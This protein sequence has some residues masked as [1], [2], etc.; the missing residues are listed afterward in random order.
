MSFNSADCA[1]FYAENGYFVYENALAT[2]TVEMLQQDATR[3]CGGD[4]G[5]VRGLLPIDSD[6]SDDDILGRYVCIHFPH[7]LS[8]LMYDTLA[9]P[10]MVDVLTSVIGQTSSACSRGPL[11]RLRASRARLGTKTSIYPPGDCSLTG[12]WIAATTPL[13]KRL[14]VGDP[15]VA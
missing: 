4:A 7:K 2:E 15:R 3:I 11:S 9:H 8:T 6:D 10:S 1:K 14:L 12:G 5:P 13:L